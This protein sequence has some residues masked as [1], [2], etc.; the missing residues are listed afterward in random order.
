MKHQ[1]VDIVTD[2]VSFWVVVGQADVSQG[3][4]SWKNDFP[5]KMS[6]FEG[7]N[8]IRW[9]DQMAGADGKMM[10]NTVEMNREGP[11]GMFLGM[12]AR[13]GL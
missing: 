1:V 4:A 2:S 13:P 3:N 9:S 6:S 10:E 8:S 12:I 5:P 11:L 7:S